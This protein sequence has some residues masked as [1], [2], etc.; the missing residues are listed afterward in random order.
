MNP[1]LYGLYTSCNCKFKSCL[2]VD[3]SVFCK[4][5]HMANKE[6]LTNIHTNLPVP[7]QDVYLVNGD[8]DYYHYGC[9]GV[10]DRVSFFFKY[11]LQMFMN[12]IYEL[13]RLNN[14]VILLIHLL[15][16][17]MYVNNIVYVNNI[18]IDRECII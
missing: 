2:F 1:F 5:M 13:C 16:T 6:L 12:A 18:F 8:V 3:G 10:D 14:T 7:G 11:I 9:D 4:Q 17:E 15:L